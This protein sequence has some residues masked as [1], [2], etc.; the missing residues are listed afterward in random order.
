[1]DREGRSP[2]PK[3]GDPNVKT[4]TLGLSPEEWRRLRVWAAEQGTGVQEIVVQ[5]VR[6]S[7][8]RR[9]RTGF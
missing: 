5:I 8:E 7:L 1:M 9:P 3:R 2:V 6:A 4:L